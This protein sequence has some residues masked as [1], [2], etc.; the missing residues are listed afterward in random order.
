MKKFFF[1]LLLVYTTLTF[2]ANGQVD[3]ARALKSHT[4][5]FYTG[6]LAYANTINLPNGLLGDMYSMWYIRNW[7]ATESNWTKTVTTYLS[8]S[9]LRYSTSPNRE[10]DVY[11]FTNTEIGVG[12]LW[13]VPQFFPNTKV[14]LGI[15]P[16]LVAE[17]TYPT[18]EAQTIS[19]MLNPFGLWS[20]NCN[21]HI[22]AYHS[23][24]KFKIGGGL[25]LSTFGVGHIPKPP[26]INLSLSQ[27]LY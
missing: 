18:R 21:G 23:I 26:Y 6:K 5:K 25:G 22:Q 9:A 17:F 8:T 2:I 3:T 16:T 19:D 20:I 15:A 24:K 10:V 13:R 27:S 14:Y 4:V 1:P 11:R 7:T 12:W